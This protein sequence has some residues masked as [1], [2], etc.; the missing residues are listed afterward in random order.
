LASG[1]GGS[2]PGWYKIESALGLVTPAD[3]EELKFT[4]ALLVQVDSPAGFWTSVVLE[5]AAHPGGLYASVD[6]QY[7][8]VGGAAA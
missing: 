5:D 6:G 8:Y 7:K 1:F 3:P 4:A 2:A